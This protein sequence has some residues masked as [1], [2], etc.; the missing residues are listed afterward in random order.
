LAKRSEIGHREKVTVRRAAVSIEKTAEK[1][2]VAREPLQGPGIDIAV[3][4]PAG[5][6]MCH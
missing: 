4:F 5:S 1:P 3:G 6:P 2:L